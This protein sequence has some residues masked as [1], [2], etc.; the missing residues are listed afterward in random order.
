M[1]VLEKYVIVEC[2]AVGGMG[3]VFVARQE[4]VGNFR[5]TVVLKKLLPD[6]EGSDEAATRYGTFLGLTASIQPLS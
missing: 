1:V 3:E 4:G 2:I 5:R 6:A